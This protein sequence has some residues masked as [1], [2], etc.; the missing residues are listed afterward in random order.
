MYL[1]GKNTYISPRAKIVGLTNP[2]PESFVIGDNSYIGDDVQ[3]MCDN[4]YIGDYAKIHHHTNIHGN[5]V[6]IGHNAWIGQYSILDG[7]GE[8]SIGN[9]FAVGMHSILWS[10]VKY[11]DTLEGCKFDACSKLNIGKDVWLAGG[12]T[13]VYPV[14]IKDKA[15]ALAGSVITKDLEHNRI[16]AGIPAKDITSAMGAPFNSVSISQKMDK[17]N[18]LLLKF[19]M[20]DDIVIVENIKQCKNDGKSYFAVDTREYKKTL[21]DIEIKFMKFLLPSKAKFTPIGELN[22]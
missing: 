10:H 4:F 8:I 3:I 5:I 9:N 15:M 19:G 20:H 22:E 16:Y 6:K 7:L 18:E 21:T 2:A 1:V 14:N 11:G 13:I 17:M 12:H